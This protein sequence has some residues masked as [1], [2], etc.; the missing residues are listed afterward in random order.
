MIFSCVGQLSSRDE[1]AYLCF[2]LKTFK[3]CDIVLCFSD[4]KFHDVILSV[5]RVVC[6]IAYHS[7]FSLL[8]Y[9][10]I[11]QVVSTAYAIRHMIVVNIRLVIVTH[12]H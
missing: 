10:A 9:Q 11:K 8:R 4:W 6:G 3:D 7:G 1:V 2:Y 12:S 5:I